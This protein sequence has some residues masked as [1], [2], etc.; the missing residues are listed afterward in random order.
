MNIASLFIP[1]RLPICGSCFWLH[2]WRASL[3]W[4]TPPS[5]IPQEPP[6][7]TVNGYHVLSKSKSI[8]NSGNP[9]MPY[10]YIIIRKGCE[11]FFVLWTSCKGPWLIAEP[12]IS[13]FRYVR[14]QHK[15]FEKTLRYV[16]AEEF[17]SKGIIEI[18]RNHVSEFT[19]SE[20]KPVATRPVSR[21]TG[22]IWK[23]KS[24]RR[25]FLEAVYWNSSAN[26]KTP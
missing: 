23:V 3:L 10:F 2:N 24:E 4:G 1:V 8:P 15:C 22:Q 11:H 18:G 7:V 17:C 26:Y 12:T 20:I 14:S 9:L 21:R 6:R 5:N 16:N 19:K 13:A 25:C